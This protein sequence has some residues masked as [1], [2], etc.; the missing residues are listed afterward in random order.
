M[1]VEKKGADVVI[2]GAED[3]LGPAVLLGCVWEG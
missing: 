3:A 1:S 2:E